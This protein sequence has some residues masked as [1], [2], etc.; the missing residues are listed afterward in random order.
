MNGPN[1][2]IYHRRQRWWHPFYGFYGAFCSCTIITI[3]QQLTCMGSLGHASMR[4]FAGFRYRKYIFVCFV[5]HY[6]ERTANSNIENGFGWK[7]KDMKSPVTTCAAFI[8][9]SDAHSTKCFKISLNSYA[10]IRGDARMVHTIVSSTVVVGNRI[11][12]AKELDNLL[13]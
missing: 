3:H 8:S 9:I 2:H 10:N 11:I 7:L 4:R 1:T 6:C 5:L 13:K 12:D